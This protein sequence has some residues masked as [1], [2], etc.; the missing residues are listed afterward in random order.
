MRKVWMLLFIGCFLAVPLMAHAQLDKILEGILGGGGERVSL[1]QVRVANL[2]MIPDPAGENQRVAFRATI[3][4]NSRQQLR[5]LL[6]IIDRSQVVSQ[7]P[8][9]YL[10]PGRNLITF[11]ESSYR[12]FGRDQR[13]FTIDTYIDRR[14]VPLAASKDFCANRSYGGWSM[15]EGGVGLG[16]LSVEDLIMS[17]DPVAPGQEVRFMV[18]LKNDGRPIRGQIRIQDRDQVVIQTDS[19]NIPRGV[20]QYQL[21]RSQYAFQRTDT[22][23]T[24]SVDVDRTP[25]QVDAAREY[26]AY[27][28]AWTLRARARGSQGRP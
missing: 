14:W 11:P 7:V 3:V 25:Q 19:V 1:D 20:S 4:N 6:A 9:A 24:V 16:Q 8:D 13:C 22:C 17:P 15:S 23:F 28:T 18:K 27:P 26:C 21:P 12:F 10:Q 5:V 2:E